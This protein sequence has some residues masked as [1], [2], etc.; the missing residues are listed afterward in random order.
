MTSDGCHIELVPG[1]V[2]SCGTG[3]SFQDPGRHQNQGPVGSAV[4]DTMWQQETHSRG[5]AG[6]KIPAWAKPERF[7]TI[8]REGEKLQR[9]GLTFLLIW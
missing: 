3:Q 6:A 5:S 2:V 4:S 8:C 7:R 9:E 1:G